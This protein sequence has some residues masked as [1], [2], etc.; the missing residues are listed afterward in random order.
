MSVPNNMRQPTGVVANSMVVFDVHEFQDREHNKRPFIGGPLNDKLARTLQ[1]DIVWASKPK[2][3]LGPLEAASIQ[4]EVLGFSVLNRVGKEGQTE[5]DFYR[6]YRIVGLSVMNMEPHAIATDA[7]IRVTV[8]LQGPTWMRNN[9]PDEIIHGGDLVIACI[10]SSTA[11]AERRANA[12]GPPEGGTPNNRYTAFPSKWSPDKMIAALTTDLSAHLRSGGERD[13]SVVPGT[14][15]LARAIR[16]IVLAGA[17]ITFGYSNPNAL[18][19][20]PEEF[21]NRL[22]EAA[23]GGNQAIVNLI[24]NIVNGNLDSAIAALLFPSDAERVIGAA[25]MPRQ[26][27]AAVRHLHGLQTSGFRNLVD[28]VEGSVKA[29]G[30]DRILGRALTNGAPGETF[31]ILLFG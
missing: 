14:G 24:T 27:R 2:Q 31:G 26:T 10:P 7:N 8:H 25:R 15:E 30:R 29:A 20:D 19:A 11:D 16:N 6:D 3:G 18:P 5:Y 4:G 13:E 1:A 22:R 21:V 17:C 9:N 28:T 12:L 23:S